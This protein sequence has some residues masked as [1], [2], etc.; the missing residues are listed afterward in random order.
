MKV[1]PSFLSLLLGLMIGLASGKASAQT[2]PDPEPP[3]LPPYEQKLAR[4]PKSISVIEVQGGQLYVSNVF[5]LLIVYGPLTDNPYVDRQSLYSKTKACLVGLGCGR[6]LT[7]SQATSLYA[8]I[9]QSYWEELKLDHRLAGDAQING[10]SLVF[11]DTGGSALTMLS[12]VFQ[13]GGLCTPFGGGSY[14]PQCPPGGIPPRLEWV[15]NEVLRPI[16]LQ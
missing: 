3:T 16:L 14:Q 7:L 2:A 6:T 8:M 9:E 10:Y 15:L 11:T 1:V 12:T 5:R 4:K 13:R